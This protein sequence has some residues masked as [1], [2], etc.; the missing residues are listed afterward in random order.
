MMDALAYGIPQVIV[1]G[2]VFERIYNA[3]SVERI[4]AGVKLTSFDAETLGD[5]CRRVV[6][7]SSFAES[8]L[9]IRQSLA[10]SGGVARIVSTIEHVLAG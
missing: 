3:D 5:A 8:A 1:P 10:A 7:D 4:G 2:R 6:A 9:A